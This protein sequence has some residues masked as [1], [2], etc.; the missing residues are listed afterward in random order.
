MHRTAVAAGSVLLATLGAG[1]ADFVHG[2]R[3]VDVAGE[4]Q[5]LI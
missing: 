1:V 4:W 2:E 5:T 3:N